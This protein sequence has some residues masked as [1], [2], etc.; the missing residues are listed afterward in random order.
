LALLS[1]AKVADGLWAFGDWWSTANGGEG[2][3]RA[4]LRSGALNRVGKASTNDIATGGRRGDRSGVS[5]T[6]GR[7][8]S[9]AVGSW[10]TSKELVDL[11]EGGRGVGSAAFISRWEREVVGYW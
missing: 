10:L 9:D 6:F 7:F 5:S 4:S 8:S 11:L 1:K 3:L 2:I